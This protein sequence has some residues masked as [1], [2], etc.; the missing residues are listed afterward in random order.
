MLLRR[1]GLTASAGI[2]CFDMTLPKNVKSRVFLNF[3]KNVKKRILELC[4][5]VVFTHGCSVFVLFLVVLYLSLVVRVLHQ[6][7]E[8]RSSPK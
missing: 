2:S 7:R 8:E 3:Q 4:M 5:L 1:A 6:V